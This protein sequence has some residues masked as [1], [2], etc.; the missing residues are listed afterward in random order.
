VTGSASYGHYNVG[1]TQDYT[2]SYAPYVSLLAPLYGYT[3][4]TAGS[5]V[6]GALSVGM[7]KYTAEARFNSVRV[8]AFEFIGGFFYTNETT[9]YPFYLYAYNAAGAKYP[10]PFDV[11]LHSDTDENYQEYAGF[12]DV[13]F[14]I[15][16]QLDVEGGVRYSTNHQHFFSRIPTTVDFYAQA[17]ATSE[18]DVSQDDVT[19]LA[20]ARWRPTNDFTAYLR[21]ATGYR[22]GGPQTAPAGTP[23]A[24]AVIQA[25]TTADYEGGVKGLLFGGRVSYDADIYHIDWNN[26][27]LNGLTTQGLLEG[28]NGGAAKVDGAE[29]E[30]QAAPLEGLTV[31]VNFGYTDA[32]LTQISAAESAA[33]GAKAG[34]P[35]P[36]T[37]KYTAS[38]LADYEFPLNDVLKGTVGGTVRYQS[39]FIDQFPARDP[40]P[41]HII[42]AY[43]TLDGR[44]GV[45]FDRY[46]IQFRVANLLNQLT[47]SNY[48]TTQYYA[49]T[50]P[51]R[52]YTISLTAKF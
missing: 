25:D 38:A 22:P 26:V 44:V 21:Y 23:G 15:T 4:S 50:N 11:L 3:G 30:L 37:S 12:A 35:L 33:L 20:T 7:D 39:S 49:T 52:T 13:D 48:S 31:G 27:Q 42:P 36:G 2:D 47:Y 40:T 18:P 8:G 14:H 16:D 51:P 28:G 46:V 17:P 19:Y 24:E 5:Q 6:A 1:I 43:A 41:T 29:V 9:Y 32:R 34:D 10:S 45:E